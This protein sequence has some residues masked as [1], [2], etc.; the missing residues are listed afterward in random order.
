MGH[1]C[2]HGLL[3]EWFRTSQSWKT[4]L[5]LSLCRTRLPARVQGASEALPCKAG[6]RLCC[7]ARGRNERISKTLPCSG[8]AVGLARSTEL[9]AW[10]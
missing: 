5:A 3:F 6:R 1:S 8:T 4:S 10:T 9:G 7:R 2:W